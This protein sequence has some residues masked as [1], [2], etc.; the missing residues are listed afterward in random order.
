[1]NKRIV[2]RSIALVLCVAMAASIP[3]AAIESGAD[4]SNTSERFIEEQ[5][6]L[7][8]EPQEVQVEA[9]EVDANDAENI[10]LLASE[11]DTGPIQGMN[12]TVPTTLPIYQDTYG[13]VTCGDLEITNNSTDMLAVIS[14]AQVSALGDWS[15]VDYDSASFTEANNGQHKLGIKL[16]DYDGIIA[17]GKSKNIAVGA[18]LPFQGVSTSN[19]SVAKV[20]VTVIGGYNADAEWQYTTSGDTITLN[21]YIGTSNSVTVHNQYYAGGKVYTNVV[22]GESN[23]PSAYSGSGPFVGSNNRSRITDIDFELGVQ[24]PENS[25][26]MFYGMSALRAVR[27]RP[28]TGAV[29]DM[30]GMFWSASALTDISGLRNWETGSVT[31]MSSM[32]RAATN[33]A[34]VSGL[35]GWNTGSVTSTEFMFW[36]ASLSSLEAFRGWNTEKI[37]NMHG[38]FLGC[39]DVTSLEPLADWDT[40]SVTNMSSMFSGCSL[41]SLAGLGAWNTEAVASMSQIF[42]D[43]NIANLDELKGWKTTS[44]QNAGSMFSG[45]KYLIDTDG[46]SDWNTENVSNMGSLF[47]NCSSIEALDLSGWGFERISYIPSDVLSGCEKLKT[48]YVKNSRAQVNL[49]N[50][51]AGRPDGCEVIIPSIEISGPSVLGRFQTAQLSVIKN[52]PPR[53]AAGKITW[54]SSNPTTATVSSDGKVTGGYPNEA[55]ITAELSGYT[56]EH[57]I[58]VI[59]L[60][61]VSL[62]A[63]DGSERPTMQPNGVFKLTMSAWAVASPSRSVTVNLYPIG[64]WDGWAWRISTECNGNK[65]EYF[66]IGDWELPAGSYR[67]FT[68]SLGESAYAN[69]TF[70]CWKLADFA[71]GNYGPN[72]GDGSS[73]YDTYLQPDGSYRTSFYMDAGVGA[74]RESTITLST[75]GLTGWC[76]RVTTVLQGVT[77]TFTGLGNWGSSGDMSETFWLTPYYG[78]SVEVTFEAWKLPDDFVAKVYTLSSREEP[79]QEV[80]EDTVGIEEILEAADEQNQEELEDEIGPADD[81]LGDAVVDEDRADV[82]DSAHE[83]DGTEETECDCEYMDKL[84]P[85]SSVDSEQPISEIPASS[86]TELAPELRDLDS[87]ITAG[88]CA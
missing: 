65:Y 12:V 59:D 74:G 32:F 53:K 47:W 11:S 72:V 73:E 60:P 31:D 27:G 78:G 75:R 39:S 69:I 8:D 29:T 44:L 23:A 61:T 88:F 34:D 16:G 41:R 3:A 20:V 81:T 70:E 54:A 15:L 64:N 63:S 84:V 67:D 86:L 46:I 82:P 49:D 77:N 80:S 76:W 21:K 52:L 6:L 62:S 56:A 13:N 30:S 42:S 17:A 40:R 68:V 37:I 5:K 45:C 87:T 85:D 83:S 22:M 14:D 79:M 36:N 1:M 19:A 4:G 10:Q 33:L 66:G 9:P 28:D 25:S 2:W 38:M 35:A 7:V 57:N 24:F 43:T 26:K 51:V 71:S 50:T 18:K 48:V 55:T 58:Q